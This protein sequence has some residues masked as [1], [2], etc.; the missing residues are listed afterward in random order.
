MG[1]VR[2]DGAR[3]GGA[4]LA[5]LV[6]LS[7][8]TALAL[9]KYRVE[10]A[11]FLGHDKDD[12]LWQLSGKV[13]PCVTCHTQPQGG[14]GWNAFGQSLQAEFRAQPRANFRTV[15]RSVL[16]READAD[17]DGSPDA[18]EFFARTLPGDPKSKPSKPLRDLQ[19]EFEQAGGLPE[20]KAKK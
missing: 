6:L 19:A 8:P 5:G 2:R 4:L 16:A 13:M 3:L 17:A 12:P 7:A 9:P 14:K 15:L 1:G 11:R 18:L 10:A 20:D